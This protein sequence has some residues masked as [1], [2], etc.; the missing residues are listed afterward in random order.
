VPSEIAI[1]LGT[2]V[3]IG[4]GLTIAM[5]LVLPRLVPFV[6]RVSAP[7]VLILGGLA[8]CFGAAWLTSLA[9]LSMALGAFIAGVAIAGSE[10]GHTIGR[11]I[12]P[13]RD[14]FTSVFF[15]SVGLLLHITW[16]YFPMNIA[17][18]LA[19][20]AVNALI[21]ALILIGLRLPLRVALIAA[22]I[23]AEVGEFS[24]VL[25][26]AGRDYGLIDELGFQNMLVSIIIT[27]IVTPL[28]IT[29]APRIAE[30]ASP[31]FYFVPLVR[32]L[33]RRTADEPA[34]EAE[35]VADDVNTPV[36][37]IIGGGVLGTNVA[38]VLD[39]TAIPYRMLELNRESVVRLRAEGFPVVQGDSTNRH[40][41]MHAGIENVR[42]VVLAISDETALS[43]SVRALRA[44]RPDILVI[45]RTRYALAADGVATAGADV[46]VTEEYESSIQVFINLL[47]HL[48]V[49]ADVIRQQEDIM[50]SNHYGLLGR[51][52]KRV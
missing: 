13:I 35:S 16:E 5:R 52:T 6:T 24:F 45:A 44:A 7:E 2:L 21:V 22:I 46:V 9:G 41:L 17:S 30:H 32:W 12:E 33:G 19:I 29:M 48:G 40:D 26:T 50:R 51:L 14:A 28:L 34:E 31:A 39:A 8:I 47:E 49:D 18:A 42:A 25:A 23:L 15:V 37:C 38:R 20:L 11:V 27:M 4:G 36:V 3:G 1:K 43:Q 10:E